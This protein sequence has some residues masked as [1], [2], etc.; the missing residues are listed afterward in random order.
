MCIRDSCGGRGVVESLRQFLL[1][2]NIPQSAIFFEK[3]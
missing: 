3:F 2:K 1:Q